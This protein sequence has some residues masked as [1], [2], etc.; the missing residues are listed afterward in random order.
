MEDGNVLQIKGGRRKIEDMTD[1][2]HLV[3]Q[4]SWSFLRKF[5]LPENAKLEELKAAMEDVVLTITE[6][7]R[8]G[9]AR[10]AE[11]I[12]DGELTTL[13]GLWGVGL[14][15]MGYGVEEENE[16]IRI[17]SS[18]IKTSFG[19]LVETEFPQSPS[20]SALRPSRSIYKLQGSM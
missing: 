8:E 7:K 9:G 2:W 13:R 12:E 19:N 14:R 20:A 16:R 1:K 4:I 3:E 18:N 5:T 11:E 6:R 10:E 17:F 15:V